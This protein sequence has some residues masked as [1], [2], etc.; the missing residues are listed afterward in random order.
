M[1]SKR[2]PV[3]RLLDNAGRRVRTLKKKFL[4]AVAKGDTLK[5]RM[6]EDQI[7]NLEDFRKEIRRQNKKGK[8]TTD[9]LYEK[10]LELKESAKLTT[11]DKEIEKNAVDR[12]ANIESAGYGSIMRDPKYASLFQRLENLNE[13]YVGVY[14]ELADREE[15]QRAM[16]EISLIRTQESDSLTD[17]DREMLKALYDNLEKQL[18][19]KGD[20]KS[21]KGVFE[22]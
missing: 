22:Y 18:Q 15:A 20:W 3:S 7:E 10:E 21:K 13:K 19:E 8:A 16:D 6:I 2:S 4:D 5:Q 1:A 14:A 12:A 17:E 11:K 9:Y